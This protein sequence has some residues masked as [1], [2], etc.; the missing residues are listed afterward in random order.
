MTWVCNCC[1]SE[2]D[3]TK[4]EYNR[5]RVECPN[6]GTYWFVDKEDEMINDGSAWFSN[7]E[8]NSDEDSDDSLSV[9]DAALI[10]ASH[11]K[12]ED[13]TFG[14]SEDELEDALY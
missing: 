6:C 14:Y 8:Y 11:G 4:E 12:D 7:D 9:Y 3:V 13:Y 10:W 2:M 1:Y 5:Y